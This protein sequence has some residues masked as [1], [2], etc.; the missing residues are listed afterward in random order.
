MIVGLVALVLLVWGIILALPSRPWSTRERLVAADRWGE[1]SGVTVL[2][3][4]R[5]EADVIGPT[6]QALAAQG[7]GLQVIVLDDRSDD[8]TGDAARAA[9]PAGCQVRVIQGAARPSG[10]TGKVWALEQAWVRA[11]TP[12][13]LL[14][15][16]DIVLAPGALGALLAKLKTQRLQLVSVMA[17]LPTTGW[18]ERLLVPAYVFFFK[19]LYP[20]ARVNRAG[21]AVAA[22]AGGC[23]LLEAAALRQVGGFRAIND[24]LIDD[25]ALASRFKA[26]GFSIW[27]GLSDAV[28]SQ[29]RYPRLT[30]F[31]NM[32]ARSAFTELEYS[33]LRLVLCTGSMLLLFALPTLGLL[34]GPWAAGGGALA[35]GLMV[36]SYLP[37]VRFYGLPGLW[38]LTLPAAAMLFLAMTWSSAWRYWRGTRAVWKNR[39]YG[40]VE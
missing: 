16:A 14:M 24:Q 32:V 1:L 27:L 20:F 34:A 7:S 9:R 36:L 4:A 29:R 13:V 6:L 10:W 25:C 30:D 33:S 12:Y 2:I 21:T 26:A 39:V 8:G 19:L 5:N 23:V 18:W 17:R 11:E 35:L 37:M 40:V 3:P 31:W 38:A 28:V 15:D 22:A